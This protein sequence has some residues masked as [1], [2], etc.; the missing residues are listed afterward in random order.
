MA[1]GTLQGTAEN[2][3][4]RIVVDSADPSKA[5]VFINNNTPTPTYVATIAGLSQWTLDAVS[6]DQLIVD[7][8]NGNPLPAGGLRYTGLAGGG[9]GLTI[10]GTSAA[11]TVFATA[12]QI[13]VNGAAAINFTNIATFQ[14]NL[15]AGQDNLS[16]NSA[17]MRVVAGLD[18][19]GTVVVNS[20]SSLTA[21][22]IN[23]GSLVIGGTAGSPAVVTIAASDASG[24]PLAKT[25]AAAASGAAPGVSSDGPPGAANA[26]SSIYGGSSS[27]GALVPAVVNTQHASATAGTSNA[28]A[29]N[30]ES[31]RD[32]TVGSLTT[33]PAVSGRIAGPGNLRA[34]DLNLGPVL[35]ALAAPSVPGSDVQVQASAQNQRPASGLFHV[36]L[37]ALFAQDFSVAPER[38]WSGLVSDSRTQDSDSAAAGVDADLLE[39]LAADLSGFSP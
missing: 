12:T 34:L 29:V 20:G 8:S 11:D 31:N 4:Y 1:A 7:F 14:F 13:T 32:S 5:D 15:G 18:D 37:D 26:L 10:V 23:E 39:L 19:A 2:N 33:V 6:G 36:S 30:D 28:S 27:A 3:V 16:I 9:D 21:D 25:A 35:P 22:H 17:S 38:R 24:N